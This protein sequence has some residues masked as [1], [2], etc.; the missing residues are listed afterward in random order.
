MLGR[1]PNHDQEV[2]TGDDIRHQHHT[3]E[4]DEVDRHPFSVRPLRRRAAGGGYVRHLEK[5]VAQSRPPEATTSV[6]TS[7]CCPQFPYLGA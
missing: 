1:R 6:P 5:F 3:E 7:T 2:G 4:T